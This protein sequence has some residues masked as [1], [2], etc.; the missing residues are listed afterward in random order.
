M[1]GLTLF[2]WM[3][4][5]LMAADLAPTGTLRAAFLGANPV[6]GHVDPQTGA[7]TGP[8][9]DIVKEMALKLGVPFSIPPAPDASRVIGLLKSGK[10]DI[11]F[12]SYDEARS[13]EVD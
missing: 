11:G 10:A 8:V 6:Q 12:L 9:A 3:A 1:R 7:I 2:V 4:A 5:S 13:K